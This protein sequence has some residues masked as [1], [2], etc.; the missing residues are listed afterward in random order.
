MEYGTGPAAG[1]GVRGALAVPSGVAEAIIGP[2]PGMSWREAV[3]LIAGRK[4]HRSIMLRAIER[5]TGLSARTCRALF[6]GEMV[7]P[8]HSVAR[9]VELALAE[10][11]HLSRSGRHDLAL[12]EKKIAAQDQRIAALERALIQAMGEAG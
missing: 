5:A 4:D 7:D 8:K 9:A 11:G 1:H 10:A 2:A 12:L 6:D 3:R